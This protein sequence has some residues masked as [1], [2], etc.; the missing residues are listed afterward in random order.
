MAYYL[1]GS[2]L[3]AYR[4]CLGRCGSRPVSHDL[5]FGSVSYA[6]LTWQDVRTRIMFSRSGL[7]SCSV[8]AM[9]VCMFYSSP[10]SSRRLA[11][12]VQPNICIISS[13]SHGLRIFS[14]TRS[15]FDA[16]FSKSFERSTYHA[17]IQ[18]S[19]HSATFCHTLA[20]PRGP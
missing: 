2:G 15:I 12:F 10:I 14:Q 13:A 19:S 17:S 16:S 18:R 1:C 5:L 8:Q 7:S 3:G 20:R 11:L 6:V 9:R 4:A